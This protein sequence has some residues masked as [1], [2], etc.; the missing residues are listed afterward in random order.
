MSLSPLRSCR[1]VLFFPASNARAIEKA[2]Q[3]PADMVIL[4]CEDAVK[5]EDKESAR[6][7]AMA[8]LR[9]GFGERVTAMRINGVDQAWHHDDLAAA[10]RCAADVIILPKV[11]DAGA[12]RRVAEASGK[13][14]LAM[15]ETARGVLAATAIAEASAGLIA[16]T[17]DLAADLGIPSAGGRAGLVHSLQRVVVAAR[18]AGIAAFDGVY[19]RLEDDE[20]FAA[21]CREGRSFGFDGKTLI[22][23]RQVEIANRCFSPSGEE[24]ETA[25]RMLAAARGGAERFEG[26]MIEAMHVAQAELLLAR[27]KA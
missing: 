16:G 20:G 27:A 2:R 21:E 24:V 17:N 26:R 13:P 3:L 10:A 25:R 19:N 7:S 18:A 11:E 12:M 9:E 23:P 14:V 5:P 1:S 6:E 8:A 15:I 22:H 4:D